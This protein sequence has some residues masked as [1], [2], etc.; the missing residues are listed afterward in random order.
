VIAKHKDTLAWILP[1]QRFIAGKG[2]YRILTLEQSALPATANLRMIK[3]LIGGST[4]HYY[5][6]EARRKVGYDVK[7]PREGV[8]IHE[9]NPAWS[10]QTHIIDPTGLPTGD[11]GAVWL[12]GETFTDGANGISVTVLS[13]T[14]TGWVVRIAN[15]VAGLSFMPS[16]MR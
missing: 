7:L 9:T 5:T 15:A 2:I 16:V 10:I 4:T 3:L 6:L 11:E 1:A 14:G 12:P 8:V 13:A